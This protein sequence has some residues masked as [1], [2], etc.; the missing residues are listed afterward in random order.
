MVRVL[1]G[2]AKAEFR[3]QATLAGTH[4]VANFTALMEK[5]TVHIFP[6]T[7]IAT[8]GNIFEGT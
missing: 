7:Q 3:Q 2:D 1:T 4:T 6:T 5:M 8:K